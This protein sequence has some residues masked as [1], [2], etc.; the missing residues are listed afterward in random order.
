MGRLEKCVMWWSWRRSRK[1]K[2]EE[3]EAE[4]EEAV[5]RT[6][7]PGWEVGGRDW[8]SW[9]GIRAWVP[10]RHCDADAVAAETAACSTECQGTEAEGPPTL[11]SQ[12]VSR[13]PRHARGTLTLTRAN[14]RPL[15]CTSAPW[16]ASALSR[17]EDLWPTR[18]RSWG[19]RAPP[20]TRATACECAK[21]LISPGTR[22]PSTRR[23][24]P[25]LL[26]QLSHY[27]SVLENFSKTQP[28]F[29]GEL[30][31]SS[32]DRDPGFYAE[33]FRLQLA[34]RAGVVMS[35]LVCL[36]CIVGSF[37]NNGIGRWSLSCSILLLL[38]EPATL[39][40][41]CPYWKPVFTKVCEQVVARSTEP[42]EP[43]PFLLCRCLYCCILC[44]QMKPTS[45]WS[46]RTGCPALNTQVF[47]L[48]MQDS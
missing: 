34:R 1:K 9:Q 25:S 24:P 28:G 41:R 17:W 39:S 29:V 48:K 43:E 23:W 30:S 7:S 2:E 10:V 42:Y 14:A 44:Q 18:R 6:G 21:L 35:A 36:G 20:D 5:T 47:P 4:T 38:W 40:Q 45:L 12:A 32:V 16:R 27:F 13:R 3:E 26:W 19:R 31:P 33:S 46:S 11:R 15:A 22:C 37:D 8:R